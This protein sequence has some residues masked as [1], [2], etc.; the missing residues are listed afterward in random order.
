M[1]GVPVPQLGRK[2]RMLV[3]HGFAAD[4]TDL[5]GK[6]G[7]R[8][9]ETLRWWQSEGGG[10][11][12]NTVP[13]QAFSD[14]L[15]VFGDVLSGQTPEQI[16]RL[17]LGPADDLERLLAPQTAL[18]FRA[19]IEREA[20]KTSGTVFGED[21]RLLSLIKTNKP[22]A[23][24]AQARVMLGA[25]FRIEFATRSRG[26]FV[27]A[28]QG[29]P[30][31]WWVLPCSLDIPKRRIFLPDCDEEKTP[32]HMREDLDAGCHL[33]VAVQAD[34]PFPSDLHAAAQDGVLLDRAL[35]S[36]FL[37]DLEAR[38]KTARKLFALDVEIVAPT[39]PD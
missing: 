29:A 30:G 16:R 8:S 9:P 3:T 12:A 4:M 25:L 33:F 6:I 27:V 5:A 10:R 35:L 1:S 36:H 34:R 7:G 31:G 37:R 28:F 22:L 18:S 26:G 32:F 23:R 39:E 24:P 17:V 19:L 14:L 11:E 2:L 15:K 21:G 13:A 38:P 20:D